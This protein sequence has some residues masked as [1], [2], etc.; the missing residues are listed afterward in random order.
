MKS[1]KYSGERMVPE[2]NKKDVVYYE[3]YSR[4][5]FASQFVKGKKILDVACGVGYGSSL[6]I[7]KEAFSVTGIDIS[8]KAINYARKNFK[9]KNVKFVTGNAEKLPFG[10]EVFDVV[11]SF[12]TIEHLR[13]PNMFLKEAKRVLKN[14]GLFIISTPNKGKYCSVNSFHVKE[15]KVSEFRKLVSKYFNDIRVFFQDSYLTSAVFEF[16]SK[17]FDM[18]VNNEFFEREGKYILIVGGNMQEKY[19]SSLLV[20]GQRSPELLQNEIHKYKE[21]VTFLKQ[22]LSSIYNS[23]GWK[24]ISFLHRL[25]IWLGI[26]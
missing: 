8:E 11:V 6:L 3:H 5:M 19:S 16:G 1:W 22:Q 4:Y 23:R 20:Y 15:F 26:K 10:N 21:D 14:D 17:D 9:R 18:I 2:T 24:V 12:E 25:R 13:Q 7:D